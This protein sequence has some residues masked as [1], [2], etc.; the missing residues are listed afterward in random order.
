MLAA[1]TC[2]EHWFACAGACTRETQ[3][4]GHEQTSVLLGEFG[5]AHIAV[6]EGKVQTEGNQ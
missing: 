3:R 6:S 1:A 5:S 4:A 2:A